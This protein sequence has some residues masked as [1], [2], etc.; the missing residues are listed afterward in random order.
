MERF[1]GNHMVQSL[2]YCGRPDV[3]CCVI[4]P[5]ASTRAQQGTHRIDPFFFCFF[6]LILL[7]LMHSAH[8][9]LNWS[10]RVMATWLFHC[11]KSILS[12][13]RDVSSGWTL[14]PSGFASCEKSTNNSI[15]L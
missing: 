12:M 14:R 7:M 9:S 4:C 6:L 13:F 1:I 5:D 11:A 10:G 8:S 15:V 3:P 2:R